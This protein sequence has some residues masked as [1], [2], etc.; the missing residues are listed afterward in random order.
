LTS[1]G[2]LSWLF[3]DLGSTLIDET[4]AYNRRVHTMVAGTG[5]APSDFCAVMEAFYRDGQKGDLEAAKHFGLRVPEWTS[6]DEKLYPSTASVLA[7]LSQNYRLGVIANQPP[8]TE[9]RLCRFGIRD[10]FSI[11]VSSAEEGLAKPD[12]RMFELAL[13]RANCQAHHAVMI[14]DRLDNDIV[15]AKKLGMRTV[16]VKQGFSSLAQDPEGQDSADDIVDTI[17]DLASLLGSS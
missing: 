16:W 3:F 5:I 6:E 4:A 11:V 13:R 9:E 15:P 8:G 10:Y 14:G 2:D 1:R 17:Q 12:R 7:L